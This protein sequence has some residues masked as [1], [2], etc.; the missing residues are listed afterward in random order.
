MKLQSIQNHNT[1]NTTKIN[2]INFKSNEHREAELRE[3]RRLREERK[4]EE[5]KRQEEQLLNKIQYPEL[6]NPMSTKMAGFLSKFTCAIQNASE[7]N[8][9]EFFG[10][11]ETASNLRKKLSP[12]CQADSKMLREEVQKMEE[13]KDPVMTLICANRMKKFV[14]KKGI[15]SEEQHNNFV[16][17]IKET[18]STIVRNSDLDKFEPED[19]ATILEMVQ[20]IE[21]SDTV[22]FGIEKQL[23]VLVDKMNSKKIKLGF[24]P[25][26]QVRS[27]FG[28]KIKK[29]L[30]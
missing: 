5:R 14:P 6:D 16:E 23:K 30:K 28:D 27:L 18:I 13:L 26:V 7:H 1:M 15:L 21:N 10:D 11:E 29:L 19:K 20:K 9:M 12:T 8:V 2:T 22:D 3:L 17:G 25:P 4:L 24:V